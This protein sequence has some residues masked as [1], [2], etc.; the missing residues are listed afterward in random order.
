MSSTVRA[1]TPG[2][3]RFSRAGMM[4]RLD[5]R[6]MVGR[7]PTHAQSLA[8]PRTESPVGALQQLCWGEDNGQDQLRHV[9][10]PQ[11]KRTAPVSVPMPTSPKDAAMPA[12]EPPL[13]PAVVLSAPATGLPPPRR[14]KDTRRR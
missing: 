13:D 4:P 6:P 9:C 2:A 12:A 11:H 8:G 10:S 5:D 3:S 7:M 14:R 1:R